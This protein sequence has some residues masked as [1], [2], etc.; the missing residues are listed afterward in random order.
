MYEDWKQ[1]LRLEVRKND[2]KDGSGALFEIVVIGD[3]TGPP[4][5]DVEI[6][7]AGA[8]EMVIPQKSVPGGRLKGRAQKQARLHEEISNHRIIC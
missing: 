5:K 2:K 3:K 1:A 7:V 4:Q 6:E 8:K